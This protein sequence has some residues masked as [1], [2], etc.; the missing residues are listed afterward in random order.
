MKNIGDKP[1]RYLVFEFHSPKN[2]G[3]DDQIAEIPIMSRMTHHIY[4]YT[5]LPCGKAKNYFYKTKTLL[6][7]K[8]GLVRKFTKFLQII[9]TI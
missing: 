5:K 8:K 9:K 2:I 1:A 3:L 4:L 7:R 6:G